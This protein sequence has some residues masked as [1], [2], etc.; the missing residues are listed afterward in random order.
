MIYFATSSEHPSL[1]EDDLIAAHLLSAVDLPWAPLQW[2]LQS[3]VPD[4]GDV[5][6]IRSC[7]D[8]H[9]FPREFREWLWSLE[10]KGVVIANGYQPIRE[11]LH[12]QYLIA[13]AEQGLATIPPTMLVERRSDTD[14]EEISRAI[15]TL[16][17]VVKPAVSLSGYQTWRTRLEDD[18]A[19]ERFAEQL[20]T[21]DLLVQAYVPEIESQGELSLIF[22]RGSFSHAVRKLPKTGDFRV[23]SEHGGSY[24]PADVAPRLVAQASELVASVADDC[25]YARVDG[26]DIRG[27][28]LLMELELIDPVLFFATHPPAAAQFAAAIVDLAGTGISPDELTHVS[29]R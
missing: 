15:G 11:T 28:L 18:A 14:L 3:S 24:A 13:Y 12:K 7:W 20:R 25:V 29:I 19:A 9:L 1:T 17:L 10:H 16:D 23:Q 5:V 2:R 6:V 8:Y 21:A 26:L 4:V 22:I 27:S